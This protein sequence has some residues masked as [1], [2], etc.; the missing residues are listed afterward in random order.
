M[1]T[2]RR[3]GGGTGPTLASFLCLAACG[4]ES[5]R[6]SSPSAPPPVT[7][8][9]DTLAGYT[10]ECGVELGPIP[11]FDCAEAHP[12]PITVDGV[13]ADNPGQCDR[14]SLIRECRFPTRVGRLTGRTWD[15][16][17]NPDVTWAFICVTK[18]ALTQIAYLGHHRQTG[19]TCFFESQEN[20]TQT[21]APPPLPEP[22][23]PATVRDDFWVDP[24]GIAKQNCPGCH[25]ADPWLHSPFIDQIRDPL[26]PELP[27]V[28]SGADRSRPYFAVASP[29]EKWPRQVALEGNACLACHRIGTGSSSVFVREATNR[30]LLRSRSEWAREWPQSH[31]MPPT[32]ASSAAEWEAT[33]GADVT[34]VLACLESPSQEHCTS[35]IPSSR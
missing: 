14:P 33:Y 18:D 6:S 17:E 21:E 12:V 9:A 7:E 16:T 34:A 35:A 22:R 19:A 4:A 29:F 27:F 30:T 5:P 1:R 2:R 23:E 11:G 13:E 24:A 8:S 28:P 32:G 3:I 25:A 31:W 15:A 26:D 10:Q 20:N